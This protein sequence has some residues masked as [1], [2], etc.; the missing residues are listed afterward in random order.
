MSCI[1][2]AKSCLAYGIMHFSW[3]G[4]I[5]AID[6]IKK[7]YG[8]IAKFTI[9]PREESTYETWS[10][11][12]FYKWLLNFNRPIVTIWN[13]HMSMH[14]FLS[15]SRTIYIIH[16]IIFYNY[17]CSWYNC[18]VANDMNFMAIQLGHWSCCWHCT[19]QKAHRHNFKQ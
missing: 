4:R 18:K 17:P 7:Y 10:F 5:T 16:Y 9:R 19:T 11:I 6:S 12:D 15:N 14:N 1:W 3:T 2:L 13:K 8:K